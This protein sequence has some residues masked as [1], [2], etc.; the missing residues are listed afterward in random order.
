MYLFFDIT[1]MPNQQ[2]ILYLICTKPVQRMFTR[3]DW[4]TVNKNID[5]IIFPTLLD[6]IDTK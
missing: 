5:M 1:K 6:S 4:I 3:N 2:L